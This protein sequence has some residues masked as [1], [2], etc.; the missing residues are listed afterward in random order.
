MALAT[1]STAKPERIISIDILRGIIMVIMALDHVRDYFSSYMYSPTDLQHATTPMFFTRWITHFCAPIFVFLAGTSAF[2]SFSRGKTKHEASR[3]LLTRGIW[4]LILELTI[5]RFGWF[6]NFDYSLIIVQVIWAIGW[7]MICLAGLIYLPRSS[8]LTIGLVMI[9]GHNLLDVFKAAEF[10]DNAIWWNFVH[11]QGFA[12]YYEQNGVFI[13]YPLIPWIGVMA[14]GYCFGTLFTKP[15][16]ERNKWFYTIGATAILLFIILRLINVYGDPAPWST[17]ENPIRTF[18]SFLNVTKYPPSLLYLLMTIGP[19]IL[20]LPILER[21]KNGAGKFFTVF[22]RVPMFYYI[23]HIYLIHAMVM[24]VAAFYNYPV[25]S[26]TAND[27]AAFP[28]AGFGFGLL[29]VYIYW[30]IT[31]IILYLP[32]RW[33]MKVKATHKNWWLSYI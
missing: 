6:F 3:F 14:T 1:N 24:I 18:V 9:F 2:L 7:S 26:F 30:L 12:N 21:S 8:I 15:L 33:F 10:A 19:A 4:L 32:C 27:T 23:L 25:A 13:I 5:L 20:L 11:E 28:K 17:Q 16:A 31:I 29:G 22:G